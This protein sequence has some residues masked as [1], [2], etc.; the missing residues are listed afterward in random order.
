MAV[1]TKFVVKAVYNESSFISILLRIMCSRLFNLA[2]AIQWHKL[3]CCSLCTNRQVTGNKV[4]GSYFCKFFFSLNFFSRQQAF[5]IEHSFSKC[6]LQHPISCKQTTFQILEHPGCNILFCGQYG[7]AGAGS[8]RVP[9][10]L[11]NLYSKLANKSQLR[12]PTYFLS[13][14][15]GGEYCLYLPNIAEN[16]SG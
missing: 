2:C 13:K 7:N 10:A 16:L 11:P 14:N 4:S 6:F 12:L 3:R 9:S 1:T 15:L 5:L 8:E